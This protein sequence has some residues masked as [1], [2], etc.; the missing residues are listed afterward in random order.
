MI[1]RFSRFF[2]SGPYLLPFEEIN[3]EWLS[4]GLGHQFVPWSLG[5]DYK[6]LMVLLPISFPA[7]HHETLGQL[8]KPPGL[9]TQ[10]F[11]T[12]DAN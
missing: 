11:S 5:V 2:L 1:S 9:C 7:T 4:C 8:P 12:A 6:S 10:R 3:E